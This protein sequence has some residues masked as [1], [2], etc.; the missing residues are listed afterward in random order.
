[1]RQHLKYTNDKVDPLGKLQTAFRGVQSRE[2]FGKENYINVDVATKDIKNK[3]LVTAIK[4]TFFFSQAL[5]KI[6]FDAYTR[7]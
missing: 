6:M 4:Q 7:P 2:F 5:E 3:T 1:L